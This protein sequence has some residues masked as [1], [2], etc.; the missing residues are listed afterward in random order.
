MKKVFKILGIILLALLLLLAVILVHAGLFEP[1]IAMEK[2]IGPYTLVYQDHIGSYYKVK[3]AMDEVYHGL[4]RMGIETYRG[5][6]IYY[7]DP[8]KVSEDKLRSEVGSILEEK[9]LDKINQIKNTFKVKEIPQ[10]QAIVVKFPIRNMLSY[11]IA[12]AK[13]YKEV[14]ILWQQ[15]AFP[16]SEY[17]LEIYDIPNKAITFIMPIGEVIIDKIIVDEP[18]IVPSP[19]LEEA[20]KEAEVINEEELLEIAMRD[21]IIEKRGGDPDDLII[22]VS[23]IEGDYASGGARNA[24]SEVGGGMWFAAKVDEVWELVWDGNGAIYCSDLI[25]Y[26]D[27]PASMISECYDEPTGNVIL[28]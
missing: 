22:T 12:P 25:D 9:D 8:Q 17:G 15:Q 5:A 18:I 2:K 20:T 21:A 10:Q 3:P 13:V 1:V 14:N 7:D 6:G 24:S 4:L 28:R 11:M 26:P 16:E 27:F 23:E 19:N